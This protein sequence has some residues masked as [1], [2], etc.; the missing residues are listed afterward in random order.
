[1]TQPLVEDC[2]Q[3]VNPG[4]EQK[5]ALISGGCGDLAGA[6][7]ERLRGAGWLVFHPGHAELDVTKADS[8]G[9]YVASLPV[10]LD[11]L[12]NNAAITRD[13]LFVRMDSSC[14]EDVIQTNLS[15]AFRLTQAVLPGMV[16]RGKG[17][18]VH[19]GSFSALRPPEGQANYASAKA[20]LIALSQSLAAEFGSSNI[21]SNCILPGFLLTRMTASVPAPDVERARRQHTLGRFNTAA[22][23]ARFIEC[24]HEMGNVSGQVFQ[25]DSRIRPWT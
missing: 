6:V 7:A 9:S 13:R 10:P 16:G 21:R 1:M 4:R 5:A 14:W 23:V 15:G 18:L 20:G 11:L 3:T 17:H 25:L 24:L 2:L 12:V 19:I 22:D 8:I